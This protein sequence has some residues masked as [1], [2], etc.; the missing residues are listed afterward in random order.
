MVGGKAQLEAPGVMP[1]TGRCS[2]TTDLCQVLLSCCS[3][4][5]SCP[6][7]C[8]PMDG[9][10]RG[11]PVLHHLPETLKLMSIESAI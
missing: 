4:A 3:V 11:F 1:D 7:L 8:D 2:V 5:Q 10:T 9:S 6:T